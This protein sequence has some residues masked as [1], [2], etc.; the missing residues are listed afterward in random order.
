MFVGYTRRGVAVRRRRARPRAVM[1]CDFD[2][3][4]PTSMCVAAG[5][6]GGGSR[7]SSAS[8][9]RRANRKPHR[10]VGLECKLQGVRRIG[11]GV[12]LLLVSGFTMFMVGLGAD[13]E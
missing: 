2:N 1:M 6:G 4:K 7:G 11:I 8:T 9:A 3:S 13:F 12:I 5:M 10:I